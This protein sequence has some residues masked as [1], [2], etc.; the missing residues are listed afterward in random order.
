[1][2]QDL[3]TTDRNVTTMDQALRTIYWNVTTMNRNY[4]DALYALSTFYDWMPVENRIYRALQV[5]QAGYYPILAIIGI[6]VISVTILI[7]S[8]GNCGLSKCVTHYLLAMASADLIV[9]ILDLV[10]R[11]I[12]I[13]HQLNFLWFLRICNIHAVLLYAATDCSV[14]FTVTFTFDRFVAITCRTLKNRYCTEKAAAVVLGTVSV[15]SFLKN[16]FWY[17]MLTGMYQL[18]NLP[19][20][21]FV[22]LDVYFSMVWGTIEFVHYIL[23]PCVPFVMILLLNVLTVRHILVSSRARRRLWAQSSGEGLRDPEMESRRKSM[24]LLFAI[25]ANFLLLWA[26]NT[27]YSVLFRMNNLGYVSTLLHPYVQ[28]LGFMFQL[29]SCSTNSCI[30]ALTL[31]KFREQLKDVLKCPF[32]P[33]LEFIQNGE[34]K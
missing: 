4:L 5:I 8:R 11:H 25:S 3:K 26:T 2:D 21:C 24:I 7:I 16:L 33:I 27:L 14:W 30:Y 13:V 15:L 19:W 22:R 23:N 17:F 31:T 6:P 32:A 34:N 20:F 10:L 12:P 28:E 18:A 1:M 29:L 9:I